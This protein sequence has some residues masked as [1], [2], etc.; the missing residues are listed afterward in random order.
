MSILLFSLVVLGIVILV[1]YTVWYFMNEKK[2]NS[3]VSDFVIEKDNK[4][5]IIKTVYK[6]STKKKNGLVSSIVGNYISKM[7]V[8]NM[9]DI[10]PYILRDCIRELIKE[11]LIIETD[12]SIAL[13]SFG[14]Q[15]Y[16]IFIRRMMPK[17]KAKK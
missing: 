6:E 14:V 9:L 3:K 8:L 1:S 13:T 10:S 7:N 4:D 17:K 15:Y 16:E 5:K 12:E 11:E 2:V